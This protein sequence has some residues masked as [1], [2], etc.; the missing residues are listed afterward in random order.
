[1][2]WC[3]FGDN[4]QIVDHL[5]LGHADARVFDGDGGV[6]LVWDDLDEK[7]W[8]GFDFLWVGDRLVADLVQRIGGVGD[9]LAQEDFLVGVE[10]VND[11]AHQLLD[12]GIECECLRH[13]ERA[14]V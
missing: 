6:S 14:G 2:P 8:L 10:G 12:V 9:Q 3:H 1:M 4:S 11:Q 13:C 5:V 7:V